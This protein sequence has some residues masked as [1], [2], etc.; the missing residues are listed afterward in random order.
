[1]TDAG[2]FENGR[3]VVHAGTS[4]DTAASKLGLSLD[5]ARRRLAKAR[6]RVA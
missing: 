4:L 5:D 2:N 3:S 1:M 6:E